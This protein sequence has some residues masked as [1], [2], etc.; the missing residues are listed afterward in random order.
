MRRLFFLLVVG[1][2]A[3]GLATSAGSAS[4]KSKPASS[5][6]KPSALA[7]QLV[8]APRPTSNP[9][10]AAFGCDPPLIWHGGPVM[11][12]PSSSPIVVTPIFWQ[13]SGHPL[14][15]K[16]TKLITNYLGDVAHDSGLHSN[17]FATMNEYSG[18][19]RTDQ[20]PSQARRSDQR[21]GPVAHNRQLYGRERGRD[22]DL[23]GRVRLR[24]LRLR[25]TMCR[26]RPS[27]SSRRTTCRSTSGTS[28]CCS[29]RS[30]SSRASTR[31]TRRRPP[32]G[33]P[34][35]STTIR[36]L[37]TA[38]TTSSLRTQPRRCTR[39]CRSRS[40]RDRLPF[41]CGSNSNANFGV[42]ESPNK[43][44]DADVEISPTSHEIMESITDPDT[45]AA[46]TTRTASRTVTNARTSTARPRARPGRSATRRS[47]RTIT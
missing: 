33:R 24:R 12:T 5:K 32:A 3:V 28:T 44:P 18:L 39:T 15:K 23:Q 25:R 38:P 30:T 8:N 4:S 45:S 47:T 11:G 17:V 40:T 43:N 42:I 20:L 21:H 13:P 7:I 34:A 9:C 2:L 31:A 22:G 10:N 26:P 36:L 35:R 46:G 14:D 19:E 41:T 1:A 29:C 27:A 6:A 16:Y 37:P